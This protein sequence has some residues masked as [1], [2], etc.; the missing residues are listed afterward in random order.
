MWKPPS[1]TWDGKKE[2]HPAIRFLQYSNKAVYVFKLN[3]ISNTIQFV[4]YEI[5]FDLSINTK[6][7]LLE[8]EKYSL[9]KQRNTLSSIPNTPSQIIM[10]IFL[11]G[12]Q[13]VSTYSHSEPGRG[14]GECKI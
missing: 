12:Q 6:N 8:A 7:A 11:G 13:A 9:Q 10:M 14:G 4:F 5:R 2:I 3:W 1:E